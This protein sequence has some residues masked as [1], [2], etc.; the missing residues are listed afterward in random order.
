MTRAALCTTREA[1]EALFLN[2]IRREQGETHPS[3]ADFYKL[4]RMINKGQIKAVLVGNKKYIPDTEIERLTN[5]AD[6]S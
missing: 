5:V 6:A 1:C 2:S 3:R 4:Y